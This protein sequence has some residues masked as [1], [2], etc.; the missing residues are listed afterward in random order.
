MM[1][2]VR[3]ASREVSRKLYIIRYLIRIVG[4][5]SVALGA[6][7]RPLRSP[8]A[9]TT[10]ASVAGRYPIACS[11]YSRPH[12]G[13]AYAIK[14]GVGS[15]WS[16][17][18]GLEILEIAARICAA[19]LA[20]NVDDNPGRCSC[21]SQACTLVTQMPTEASVEGFD[22][23]SVGSMAARSMGCRTEH[24]EIQTQ[25][26]NRD[27]VSAAR[28]TSLAGWLRSHAPPR[29]APATPPRT[30]PR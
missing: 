3:R 10:A 27:L 22:H 21:E 15:A 12:R 4:L 24:L 1:L 2:S 18:R 8:R 5:W 28:L 23:A 17:S 20:R 13:R 6:L 26:D 30:G 29:A 7:E 19:A 25:I 9:A 11:I 16:A 14:G